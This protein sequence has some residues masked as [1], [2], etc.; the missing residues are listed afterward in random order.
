MNFKS[1]GAQI[2]YVDV[3][4]KFGERG[5]PELR[6][7]SGYLNEA[8]DYDVICLKSSC[9]IRAECFSNFQYLR[10]NIQS[11]FSSRPSSI[12]LQRIEFSN[13]TLLR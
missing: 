12:Q 4:W 11:E 13:T 2:H 9:C 1:V 10:S 7:H 3:L 6:G 5:L 8:Q